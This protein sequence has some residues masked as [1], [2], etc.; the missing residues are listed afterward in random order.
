VLP[1]MPVQATPAP[2]NEASRTM[3]IDSSGAFLFSNQ[4]D[5]TSAFSCCG[6][7]ALVEFQINPTTGALTQL[8]STPI[9]LV[10]TA[11]KIVVAPPQ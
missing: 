6:A 2:F 10:G 8:P 11:S 5:Y 7:D 4:N 1:E 9:T 3:A